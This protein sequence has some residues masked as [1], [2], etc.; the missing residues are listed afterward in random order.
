[1]LGLVLTILFATS[2]TTAL[3]V[4]YIHAWRRPPHTGVDNYWRGVVWLFAIWHP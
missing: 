1:M 3:R 4:L 2:F